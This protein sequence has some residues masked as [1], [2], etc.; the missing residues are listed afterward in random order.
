[1]EIC[2]KSPACIWNANL[3]GDKCVLDG[4]LENDPKRLADVMQRLIKSSGVDAMA[5]QIED[6]GVDEAAQ[7]KRFG[8]ARTSSIFTTSQF[9]NP[10]ISNQR[11]QSTAWV[12]NMFGQQQNN[13]GFGMQNNVLM[14]QINQMQS[15]L[16]KNPVCPVNVPL[17]Q[18]DPCQ[19][20][21]QS[22][23][24]QNA[25]MCGQVKGCCFDMNLFLYKQMFGFDQI[26]QNVPVCHR[27]VKSNVYEWYTTQIA[28][29]VWMPQFSESV[30]AKLQAFD[31]ENPEQ[32][33]FIEKCPYHKQLM[34][35]LAISIINRFQSNSMQ[36]NVGPMMSTNPMMG[37]AMGMMGAGGMMGGAGSMMNPMMMMALGGGTGEGAKGFLQASMMGQMAGANPMLTLMTLKDNDETMDVIKNIVVGLSSSYGWDGI[38]R[39][40][41]Q[42]F[43]GCWIA[44]EADFQEGKCV[45][46]FDITTG[47]T[48]KSS[49]KPSVRF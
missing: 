19:P 25:F 21:K 30:T 24:D 23:L 17:C 39:F 15:L 40:E 29:P 4:N 35:Q 46:A 44:E 49:P 34:P 41:C 3:E 42:M 22:A 48:I 31:Q 47:R 20:E 16:A 18:R 33:G 5:D 27:A 36:G 28:G 43:G 8:T 6:K 12:G 14:P 32:W 11:Q 45:K 2:A 38:S 10:F 13:F 9:N 37:G 7:K 26:Y 1:M